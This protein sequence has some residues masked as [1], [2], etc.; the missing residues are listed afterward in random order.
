[1]SDRQ[2]FGTDDL[3]EICLSKY[4]SED[5]RIC[6]LCKRNGDCAFAGRLVPVRDRELKK[7]E[8][9]NTIKPTG[10]VLGLLGP[11]ELCFMVFRSV[12]THS[13]LQTRP[14]R[15]ATIPKPEVHALP[16]AGRDDGVLFDEL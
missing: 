9:S 14:G 5:Y 8:E 15:D 6:E 10:L 1:M 4:K 13:T 12:R 7:V 11:R 16:Q 2:L 3:R